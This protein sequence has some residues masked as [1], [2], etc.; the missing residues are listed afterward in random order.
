[1]NKRHIEWWV[2]KLILLTYKDNNIECK[3]IDFDFQTEN[4][5]ID[6]SILINDEY[7]TI[8]NLIL[9]QNEIINNNDYISINQLIENKIIEYINKYLQTNL[10][11]VINEKSY[12]L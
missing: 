2:K 11:E 3:L 10:D 4:L 6:Y 8:I 9:D 12:N 5:K 7:I 1:M